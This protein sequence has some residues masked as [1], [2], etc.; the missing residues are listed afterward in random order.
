MTGIAEQLR[1]GFTG[2]VLEPS[3]SGYDE[4][5]TIFNTMID[6]RPAVIAQCEVAADVAGAIRFARERDLELAVRGGGHS[7]AGNALTDG[8]LV[9]DLRRMNS[10]TVDPDAGTARVG[11]GALMRDLDRGTQPY[12]LATTG[13][14]VS[15]TGVG[16]FALG[17]GAGWLDRRFGLACDNLRSVDLVTADG[18]QVRA[19]AT[20][21]PELFW[22]LHGG[23][24]NFGVATEFTFQLHEVPTM[25]VALLFWP[26]E[27]MP[28]ILPTVR[29]MFES[30]PD[31]AN[32]GILYLTAPAEEF[33]PADL[34]DQ[35][36]CLVAVTWI[37]G[38]SDLRDLVAPLLAQQPTGQFIT[39]LPY[40]D[41]QCLIDDPPG[42]RNYW[43][44]EYLDAL[45]DEA[46]AAF[47]ARSLELIHPEP[48]QSVLFAAGGAIART[49]RDTPISWRDATWVAH[50]FGLWSD[51]ADDTRVIQWTRA[52]RADLRPWASGA[53]YLNF[54][55]DEGHDRVVDGFG[56]ENY[57]RLAQIKRQ[58]DPDNVFRRNHNIKPA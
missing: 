28:A 25:S 44:A 34:V 10:V 15:T 1:T 41:L 32:G 17:G 8:G 35:L 24:G 11:G 57:A 47:H 48:A 40:A 7:V 3:D 4:A 43:S 46:L 21:N 53:V 56:A 6:R 54:I 38:E 27:Q 13:G 30:A 31:E 42:Y 37:G 50:P 5:R 22:A 19:S 39:E 52:L 9:V 2:A 16:G 26:A 58:Y 29:D 33:I 12:G 23:G 18:E 49:G 51:P 20:E 14:R 45:P 36:A 55:G